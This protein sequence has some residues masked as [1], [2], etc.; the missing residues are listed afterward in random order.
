MN[1]RTPLRSASINEDSHAAGDS[2]FCTSC[3]RPTVPIKQLAFD[4]L[5]AGETVRGAARKAKCSRQYV[6]KLKRAA[7]QDQLPLALVDR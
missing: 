2:F 5:L 3:G 1:R 6:Q 4:A 7:A